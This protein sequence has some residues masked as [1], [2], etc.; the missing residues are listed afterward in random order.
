MNFNFFVNTQLPEGVIPSE[1]LASRGAVETPGMAAESPLPLEQL[2]TMMAGAGEV[3]PTLVEAELAPLS[4]EALL[5]L[6]TDAGT[7]MH[8]EAP[9]PVEQLEAMMGGAGEGPRTVG[10]TGLA[11]MSEEALA[12]LGAAGLVGTQAEAPLSIEELNAKTVGAGGEALPGLAPMSEEELG[13]LGDTGPPS[14][15]GS[16]EDDEKAKSRAKLKAGE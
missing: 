5:A 14:V 13:L 1:Q 7:E 11:P 3:P 8:A 2:E 16:T 9:I 12:S 15:P 6:A 4:Q 10:E